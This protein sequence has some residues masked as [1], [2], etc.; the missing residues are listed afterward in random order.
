MTLLKYR[1]TVSGKTVEVEATGIMSAINKVLKSKSIQDFIDRTVARH[2]RFQVSVD[3][4][5]PK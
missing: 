1:I 5:T 3:S 4:I 2:G